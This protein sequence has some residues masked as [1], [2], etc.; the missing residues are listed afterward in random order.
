MSNQ[1]FI[2]ASDKGDLRTVRRLLA[3]NKIDINARDI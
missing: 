2:E 1:D 3:S